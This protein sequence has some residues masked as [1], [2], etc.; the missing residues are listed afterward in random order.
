[1]RGLH[2]VFLL[3]HLEE[4]DDDEAEPSLIDIFETREKAIFY[5]YDN[6]GAT[7]NDWEALD[8]QNNSWIS[9]DGDFLIEQRMVN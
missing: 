5:A 1:M 8:Y 6:F 3:N 9:D 2:C 7:M 4:I